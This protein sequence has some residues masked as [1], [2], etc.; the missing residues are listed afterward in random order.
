MPGPVLRASQVLTPSVLTA[1]PWAMDCYYARVET[2]AQRG[3]D[4]PKVKLTQ[5]ANGV[6]G[7]CCG[8][9]TLPGASRVRSE[10]GP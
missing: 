6:P 7:V 2:E 3:S 9:T 8:F 1:T 5:P 10:T 4:L